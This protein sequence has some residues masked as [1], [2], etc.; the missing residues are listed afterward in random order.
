MERVFVLDGP[1]RTV[2]LDG[3]SSSIHSTNDAEALLLTESTVADYLQF[4][5][6]F[7]RGDA[8]GAFALIESADDIEP[9]DQGGRSD[10]SALKTARGL[11]HPVR[12]QGIETETGRWLFETTVAH[13]EGLFR[14]VIAVRPNGEVEMLDDTPLA[15]L[16]GLIVRQPPSL[17]FDWARAQDAGSNLE[18]ALRDFDESVRLAPNNANPHRNRALA[19]KLL[20]RHDEALGEFVEAVRLAP[21]KAIHA[22]DLVNTFFDL[23]RVDEAILFADTLTNEVG[24]AAY[25]DGLGNRLRGLGRTADAL[26][27][28][29]L[30]AKLDPGNVTYL[31]HRAYALLDLNRIDEAIALA[32][33]FTDRARQA[34]YRFTLGNRLRTMGR[35][36][37]ALVQHQAAVKLTPD[38]VG[39]RNG[40]IL[41]LF[42]LGRV[43]EAI[44]EALHG[45]RRPA[46]DADRGR[47]YAALG[48][49][50]C[51]FGRKDEA[52]TQFR[53]A[54]RLAPSI[55]GY[56][57]DLGGTLFDLDR[58]TEAL[59]LADTFTAG[60]ANQAS[61][62]ECLG[63]RLRE[64]G[65]D[66]EALA[67]Y[68]A[69]LKSDRS[70]W[71]CRLSLADLLLDLGRADDAIALA[72]ELQLTPDQARFR[73]LLGDMLRRHGRTEQ[74]HTQYE[75]ATKL[76][77]ENPMYL[78]DLA[79]A[80]LDLHHRRSP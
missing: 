65:R 73:N 80:L 77:S 18:A 34:A 72:G 71:E 3:K 62:R 38:N 53:E 19:L 33:A 21:G 67:Q 50:L 24:E 68:Q 11:A 17:E 8:G 46:D 44:H 22:Q 1:D 39:Y 14:A 41:T 10:T 23:K 54:V 79:V 9:A 25:R 49:L 45:G 6:Y 57:R 61:Y 40:M 5:M 12:A 16:E 47:N 26:T 48:N 63:D 64:R 32:D 51:E 37:E 13:A 58:V 42:H 43:D 7:L 15:S 59:A 4:F 31:R 70:S 69:A 78:R 27:Q 75:E 20:G 52:L 35:K 36:D 66:I 60:A 76:V 56:L 2:Q 28:Y 55:G 29:E 30:A 74:A